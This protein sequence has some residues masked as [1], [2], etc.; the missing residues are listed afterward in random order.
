MSFK[1][2]NNSTRCK[3]CN[4]ILD[5]TDTKNGVD[6]NFC[7]WGGKPYCNFCG[8]FFDRETKIC[9]DCNGELRRP[10]CVKEHAMYIAQIGRV[11]NEIML[12]SQ[13]R[14]NMNKVFKIYL[15]DFKAKLQTV[16]TVAEKQ[17][18]M[19]VMKNVR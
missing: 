11:R 7:R 9:P 12:D 2:S 4:D 1:R 19:K 10:S 14:I 3:W 18:I 17:K 5:L 8:L 6:R 16:E 13:Q 15:K